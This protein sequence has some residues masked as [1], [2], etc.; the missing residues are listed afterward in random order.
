VLYWYGD[1]DLHEAVINHKWQDPAT[2]H[3][4]VWALMCALNGMERWPWRKDDYE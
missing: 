2:P 3:C 1:E 4:A